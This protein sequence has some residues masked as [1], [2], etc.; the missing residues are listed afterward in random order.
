MCIRP[1]WGLI[2]AKYHV[3]FA[4]HL[5]LL[6]LTSCKHVNRSRCLKASTGTP[7]GLLLL[8]LLLTTCWVAAINK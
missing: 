5:L 1:S 8:L 4:V 2:A 3:Q 7:V 6:W